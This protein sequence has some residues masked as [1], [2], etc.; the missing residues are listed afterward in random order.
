MK[1]K[2]ILDTNFLLV[3]YQFHID[4]FKEMQQLVEGGYDIIV[5]TGVRKELEVI[6][7]RA[8]RHA[9]GARLALKILDTNARFITYVESEGHVDKWI[10]NYAKEHR[11]IVCTNDK[12][13]R[14]RSKQADLRTITMKSRAKIGMV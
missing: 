2:L 5:P 13:L 10:L 6:A 3:P 14:V 4:V 9:L 11:A 7:S 12:L 1:K 8:G